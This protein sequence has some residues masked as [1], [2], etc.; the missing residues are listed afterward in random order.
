[1]IAVILFYRHFVTSTGMMNTIIQIIIGGIIY[2]L[3]TLRFKMSVK[4]FI[5]LR[6][7]L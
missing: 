6:K 3:L 5:E 2:V 7:S 1:M 4:D